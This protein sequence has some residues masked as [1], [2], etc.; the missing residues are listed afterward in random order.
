M[1]G[2][3]DWEREIERKLRACDVF[4]LLVSR[5]SMASDYIVDKEIAVIRERHANGEAVHFYPLLL[6]PT[7]KIV[8][9]K[10]LDKNLRPKDGK[11]LPDFSINERYRH[12]SDAFAL[13]GRRRRSGPELRRVGILP[14]CLL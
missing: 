12:M 11:P 7:P 14:N 13:T 8:L 10:V 1:K 6:T 4:I 5:H 2:G 3:A 9:D